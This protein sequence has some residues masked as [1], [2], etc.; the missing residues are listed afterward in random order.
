MLVTFSTLLL[1]ACTNESQSNTDNK[2]SEVNG[3]KTSKITDDNRAVQTS[4]DITGATV[5]TTGNAVVTAGTSVTYNYTN[6]TGT[7]T[8]IIWN[9]QGANPVGSITINGTGN[10]V[11]VNYGTN[12]I[13]GTITADGTGGTAAFCQSILNITKSGS[14]G[15]NCCSPIMTMSYECRGSSTGNLGGFITIKSTLNCTIDW[16]NVLKIDMRVEGGPKFSGD[17]SLNGL[18][19]GTLY[20]P[21]DIYNNTLTEEF[22]Y[23]GCLQRVTTKA[24]IYYKNGCAS[25]QLN[26]E[27]IR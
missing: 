13:S 17:S 6:N 18:K 14:S 7:P 20:P 15:S 8:S 26:A 21:F 9:V 23:I 3:N 2:S 16:N 10:T 24:T 1:F 19:V 11:T 25:I 5:I 27:A 4:C 12:F 22:Y